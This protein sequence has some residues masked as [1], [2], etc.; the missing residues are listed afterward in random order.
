[1]PDL[2]HLVGAVREAVGV[3]QREPLAEGGGDLEE[4]PSHQQRPAPEDGAD[5]GRVVVAERLRLRHAHLE[6]VPRL[7]RER[8]HLR[9]RRSPGRR[10][11]APVRSP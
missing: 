2:E 4:A 3:A 1:M 7:L 5:L 10:T 8:V 6:Q 9:P 11:P